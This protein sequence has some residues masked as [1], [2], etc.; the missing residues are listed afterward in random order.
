MGKDAGCAEQ[1]QSICQLSRRGGSESSSCQRGDHFRRAAV[2]VLRTPPSLHHMHLE[3]IS[4]SCSSWHARLP[5]S[6]SLVET[7]RPEHGRRHLGSWRH[8]D[9]LTVKVL[10]TLKAAIL[11]QICYAFFGR[12]FSCFK[13]SN[14]PFTAQGFMWCSITKIAILFRK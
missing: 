10:Y 11:S 2:H 7:R 14:Q 12:Y 13:E 8:H 3:K 5:A 9:V 4:K 6:R 1:D